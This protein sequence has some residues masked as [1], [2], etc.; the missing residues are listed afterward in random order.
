MSNIATIVSEIS[1]GFVDYPDPKEWSLNLFIYGCDHFC[2]NCSNPEL[3]NMGPGILTSPRAS[4]IRICE[5]SK[6]NR[7]N[8]VC[9]LGGDPL[10]FK[11][12][13][14]TSELLLLLES[15]HFDVCLFTGYPVEFVKRLKI[16]G[17]KFLKTGKYEYEL[18]CISEKTDKYFQLASTNQEL[19]DSEFNLLSVKGRYYFNNE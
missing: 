13:E 12:R 9:L 11:N 5:V 15:N 1:L 7:T 2:H 6:K 17:F 3:W 18:R 16:S 14:F 10:Y 4:L 19:Y 8:K